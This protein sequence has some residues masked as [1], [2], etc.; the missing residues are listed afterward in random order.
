MEKT[1]G[2]FLNR[3]LNGQG[4]YIGEDVIIYECIFENGCW[5]EMEKLL[6][7]E[8]NTQ[9]KITMSQKTSFSLS[10]VS[11]RIDMSVTGGNL[12]IILNLYFTSYVVDGVVYKISI[13]VSADLPFTIKVSYDLLTI[14]WGTFNNNNEEY[15]IL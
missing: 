13:T 2:N 12:V 15:C 7:F 1:Q 4:N 5:M 10:H 6:K 3:K 11:Q 9:E 14:N 8:K